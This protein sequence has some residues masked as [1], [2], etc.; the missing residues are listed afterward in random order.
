MDIEILLWLQDLREKLGPVVD[1]VINFISD[2]NIIKVLGVAICYIY[3]CHDKK[4][5]NF[6][7]ATFSIGQ[8]TVQ[9]IKNT[10]CVYRPWIR[11]SRIVPDEK[12]LASATGY[13][14]PSGHASLSVMTLGAVAHKLKEARTFRIITV[15]IIAVVCFSR[16]YLGYHTPQDVIAGVLIG[17]VTIWFTDRVMDW[18]ERHPEKET[19]VLIGGLILAA[20]SVLYTV[21]KTYPTDYV[22]GILLADPVE[23]QMDGLKATG[24][25]TAVVIGRYLE[26]QLVGFTTDDLTVRQKAV[27]MTVGAVLLLIVLLGVPAG[28]KQWCE[29]RTYTFI[30]GFMEMITMILLAPMA[31]NFIEKRKTDL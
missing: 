29:I 7:F 27:R 20:V 26:P 8:I 16:C 1:T 17:L 23:M 5:G 30:K 10:L 15:I 4:S 2:P 25:F 11:D 14:F 13:S 18:L 9:A 12:S 24:Y 22:D 21:L 19:A 31:F 28:L 3:W 6:A